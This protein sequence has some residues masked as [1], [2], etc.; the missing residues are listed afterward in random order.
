MV[1]KY[2]MLKLVKFVILIRITFANQLNNTF[3]FLNFLIF[4]Y[5]IN[6]Y[7]LNPLNF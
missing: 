4:F 7:Y 5:F 3:V 6:R 2:C 1:R